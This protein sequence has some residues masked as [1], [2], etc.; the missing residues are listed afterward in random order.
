M[1]AWVWAQVTVC[2]HVY[3]GVGA[4]ASVAEVGLESEFLAVI[5]ALESREPLLTEPLYSAGSSEIR[6]H[7]L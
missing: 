1:H 4:C 3:L 6:R 2:V 7:R 5:P